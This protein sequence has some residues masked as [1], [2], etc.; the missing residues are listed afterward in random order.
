MYYDQRKRPK[1]PCYTRED[2]QKMFK[3]PENADYKMQFKYDNGLDLDQEM[4]D[5]VYR[6]YYRPRKISKDSKLA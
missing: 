6:T 1:I 5:K 4:L 3:E 2:L